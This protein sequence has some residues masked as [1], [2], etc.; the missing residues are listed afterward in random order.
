M[1]LKGEQSG[2]MEEG[3]GDSGGE[4]GGGRVIVRGE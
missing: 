1:T 2:G 4:S 3:M